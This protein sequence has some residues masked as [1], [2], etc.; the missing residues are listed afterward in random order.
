ML[1]CVPDAAVFIPL[2]AMRNFAKLPFFSCV[3]VFSSSVGLFPIVC[4]DD[5]AP[6]TIGGGSSEPKRGRGRP[7][8]IRTVRAIC[9]LKTFYL[10]CYFILF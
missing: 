3:V 10:F 2:A 4:Q 7:P 5:S 1:A 6:P 8:K 9:G